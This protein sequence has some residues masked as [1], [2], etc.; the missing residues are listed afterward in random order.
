MTP[1]QLL[2]E[3]ADMSVEDIGSVVDALA[4]GAWD[5]WDCD[6]PKFVGLF[7]ALE[8]KITA[9]SAAAHAEVWATEVPLLRDALRDL[10]PS[11][12]V[13]SPWEVNP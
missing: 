6:F 12:P 9:Q 5:E 11:D 4:A 1:Q 10:P 3:L 2:R 8:W 13:Q 7:G